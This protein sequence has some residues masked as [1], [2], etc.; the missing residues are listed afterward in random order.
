MSISGLGA[1]L[2]SL[3][4]ARKAPWLVTHPGLYLACPGLR[5]GQIGRLEGLTDICESRL[6]TMNLRSVFRAKHESMNDFHG[7]RFPFFGP[8][9][10]L[11]NPAG[12]PAIA[13]PCTYQAAHAPRPVP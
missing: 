12:V 8:C 7:T 6:D 11:V 9:T 5:K 1:V 13:V 3:H 4:G 10:I 2:C